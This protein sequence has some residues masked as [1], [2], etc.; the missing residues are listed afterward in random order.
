MG[1]IPACTETTTGESPRISNVGHEAGSAEEGW[2]RGAT[3]REEVE[4]ILCGWHICRAEFARHYQDF[5]RSV[6][7]PAEWTDPAE[8][9]MR[10]A[11]H[12]IKAEGGREWKKKLWEGEGRVA[13]KDPTVSTLVQ[14]PLGLVKFTG[15]PR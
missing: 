12:F 8:I 3:G 13:R 15:H 6:N 5:R 1:D 11:L 10:V 9:R 4:L 2:N 7:E 14:L